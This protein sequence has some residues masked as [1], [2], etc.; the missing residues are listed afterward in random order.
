MQG[1]FGDFLGHKFLLGYP[2]CMEFYG[3]L[4]I[5]DFTSVPIGSIQLDIVLIPFQGQIPSYKASNWGLSV[6][7]GIYN[8]SIISY[9]VFYE[10]N[11]KSELKNNVTLVISYFSGQF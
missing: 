1:F 4:C 6:F 11:Q 10:I 8:F 2:F 5:E 7:T 3:E 9:P